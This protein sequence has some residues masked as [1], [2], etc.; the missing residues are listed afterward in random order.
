[1][2]GPAEIEDM[3]LDLEAAELERKAALGAAGTTNA[4]EGETMSLLDVL[5]LLS[6]FGGAGAPRIVRTS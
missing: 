5:Q 3:L 2:I 1:M 6:F 4:V